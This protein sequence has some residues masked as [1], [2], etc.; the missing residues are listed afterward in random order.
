M[1]ALGR[2]WLCDAWLQVS[3]GTARTCEPE[4]SIPRF[5]WFC[6]LDLVELFIHCREYYASSTLLQ[7]GLCRFSAWISKALQVYYV[8]YNFPTFK[9]I[10]TEPG[11]LQNEWADSEES[12]SSSRRHKGGA[13][14]TNKQ[15]QPTI[16]NLLSQTTSSSQSPPH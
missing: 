2:A 13:K 11:F 1:S 9:D 4:I 14:K 10:A 6:L 3:L 12:T 8:R 16:S 7:L 5:H 15:F